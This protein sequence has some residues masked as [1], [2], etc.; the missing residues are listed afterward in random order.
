MSRFLSIC[1]MI[2]GLVSTGYAVDGFGQNTT[3]GAG[4]QT[5]TVD[6]GADFLTYVETVDT[7]YIIQVS[8]TIELADADNGRVRIQSNKTILGIGENPTIIGSLGFK[9][10]CS[11]VIIER[12]TLTCP[13]DYTSEEDAISVKERI[14]NVFIT[15]CTI[16]D[17]WDGCVDIARQSD[18]V[19]VSWCKF[20][21][22][23]P[24]D[25][26]DR[27]ALV[28]NTDSSGDE[29]TLHVT[30]HHN[31]FGQYCMQRMPSLRYGRGHIYNNYYHC[32][33]NIYCIWSRI[34]AEALVENNYFK[35]INEAYVNNRD[36]AP[37]E[38]WGKIAASGNILDQCT[39]TVHPGTDTVFAPPYA[40]TLTD[41]ALVPMLVQWGAGADGKDGFP[42][43]WAFGMYGDFDL[44]GFVDISDFSTLA[45]YWLKTE[46]IED[47]DYYPDGIVDANELALFVTHW[48]YIPPDTTPPAAPANL[49]ALGEDGQVPLQWADNEEE[50]LA[51]YNV[52]R[53][54]ASGSGYTKLN[55]S[56]VPV[57]EYVDES[58]D[59]GT[60]YYYSI[61]AVDTNDN[62][63]IY[64]VEGCAVPDSVSD[65]IVIQENAS[66][67][68]TGF[69][70]LNGIVD[71]EEHA[72]Y[73]G[74][75]Y[76]DTINATGSG[77]DW[78][79][80]ITSADT[81]TFT[82]RFANG[83]SARPARLLVNSVEEVSILDF[84]ATGSWETWTTVSVPVTLT[85]GTKD[86]RLEATTSGGCA[87]IDSFMVSG[88]AP[89]AAVCQ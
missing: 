5:V 7:P 87:N 54:T 44:N 19:T 36:G 47:A 62:E 78:R 45:G 55:A 12:L 38:E 69:C 53:S 70:G 50:D 1:V 35:E 34:Q 22:T 4:G 11:N 32:P 25:N 63:S 51:G 27:V 13:E 33:G 23:A 52:Y 43:H 85:A 72:G 9:N 42:P 74:Y 75:G 79:I 80:H 14:T 15:Q 60:M 58:A 59:N 66:M 17:S 83:S 64:S 18:W 24:N 31:W 73:T 26:N 84:P 3:G 2:A 88:A 41:T 86:I 8:G 21:F 61:T 20:Y 68:T 81:Y 37:V 67:D 71:T 30:F 46:G 10:D 49:W 29:G 6:N 40:Y 56:V 48:I 89:E 16:Y 76:C 39:G 82:W 65:S 77:I 28:G 57:S